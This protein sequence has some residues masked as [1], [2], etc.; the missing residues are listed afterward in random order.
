M[1]QVDAFGYMQMALLWAS[2]NLTANNLSVGM[3]GSS[4]YG[5]SFLDSA[6]CI[7]FGCLLGCA[8]TAYMSTFGPAS[9]NRTMVGLPSSD[10]KHLLI[11]LDHSAIYFRV[12]AE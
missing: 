4:I 1:N 6:L 12:V 5:L 10:G 11:E 9:G 7:I 2:A 3:L 8:H